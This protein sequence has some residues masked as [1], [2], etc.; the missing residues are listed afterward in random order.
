MTRPFR[1][2]LVTKRGWF[3]IST[4]DSRVVVQSRGSRE[5]ERLGVRSVNTEQRS[6]DPNE[7]NRGSNADA[8]TAKKELFVVESLLKETP[9]HID[10]EQPSPTCILAHPDLRC[11]DII[12]DD[13]LHIVAVIDL[14][15]TGTGLKLLYSIAFRNSSMR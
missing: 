12:M 7:Q 3:D 14:E 4:W 2:V 5:R 13:D 9:K 1:R 6:C 11:G 10:L 15:F 8:G